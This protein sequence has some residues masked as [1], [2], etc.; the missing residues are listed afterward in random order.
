MPLYMVSIDVDPM[1][2]GYLVSW[3]SNICSF[4]RA[5]AAQAWPD[6][7]RSFGNL[8]I[9]LL[10]RAKVFLSPYVLV[11]RKVYMAWFACLDF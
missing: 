7:M 8:K 5:E 9:E 1:S 4:P 10:P 11:L 2:T 6:R 3:I